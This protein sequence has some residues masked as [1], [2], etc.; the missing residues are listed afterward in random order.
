MLARVPDAGEPVRDEDEGGHQQEQDGGTVLRV[1][2]E[3]ACDAHE[4]QQPCGL[5]QT[6]QRR[7]LVHTATSQARLSRT[8]SVA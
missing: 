3:L 4:P 5:Q 2:V 1:A 8:R 6:N 7:R